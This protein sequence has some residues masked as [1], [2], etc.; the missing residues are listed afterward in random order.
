MLRQRSKLAAAIERPR[1]APPWSI[2]L[3]GVLVL[4]VL[5]AIYP[6][7]ALVNRIIEAPQN[8]VTETY[9]VNLL[10]TDPG[11]PQLGLLLAR[12]RLSSGLYAQLEQTLA[13]LLQS[14]DKESE[15]TDVVF[16]GDFLIEL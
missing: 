10:R 6:H 16:G 3:L 7:K 1:L 13:R 14:P 12:H 2:T 11:N 5:V 4:G 8:A 15:F 9:L